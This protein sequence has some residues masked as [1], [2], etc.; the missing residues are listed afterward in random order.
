MRAAIRV[1]TLKLWSSLAGRVATI[2]LVA[3]VLALSGVIVAAVASGNADVIAKLGPRAGAD[4]NGL[5]SSAAQIT[6]AGGLG[7]FGIVLAWMFGREFTEGTVSALF[8]LPIRRATVSLAKLVT[9]GIWAAVVAVL[10]TTGILVAGLTLG[11]GVPTGDVWAGLARH[12]AL[13]MMT[14]ALA[15][16]VGWAA[17]LLR[18]I[19]GGVGI[20]AGLIVVGQFSVLAGAGA[21]MPLAAPALWAMSGGKG[22]SLIQLAMLLPYV[23]V[24]AGITALVWRRLQ[25]DR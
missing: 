11:L 10:L 15:L 13:T 23:A 12:L 4:W 5:L 2:A 21:W 25:L 7:G 8:G 9:Y 24:A 22:A 20:T 18:S 19:L 3:G 6:A 17:T 16:P 1:E 14:A